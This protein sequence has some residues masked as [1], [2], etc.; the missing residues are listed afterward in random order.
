MPL[1]SLRMYSTFLWT[2]RLTGRM[3]PEVTRSTSFGPLDVIWNALI[4]LSP[5]LGTNRIFPSDVSA[6]DPDESSIG[7][8]NGCCAA[9]PLPPVL[10][11]PFC[12]SVP[13]ALRRHHTTALAPGLLVAL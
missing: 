6:I 4:V 13:L 3:P 9:I 1:T 10:T 12:V 11:V 8:P 7:K 5:A 2:V